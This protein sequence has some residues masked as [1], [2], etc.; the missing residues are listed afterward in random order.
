M[1]SNPQTILVYVGLDRI[2]DSLLKLPFIQN[3]RAAFPESYITWVAGKD[4]SV[5][6]NIMEPFIKGLLDEVI[7]NAGIGISPLE[8]INR[9]MKD[10][11]FDLIID[12]QRVALASLVL[13]RIQHREFISPFGN[14]FFSNRKPSPGYNFPK[15]M[16]RQMLDLLEIATGN[17]IDTPKV[18]ALRIEPFLL[19]EAKRALPNGSAYVGLFPGS[20]GKPKCWPLENFIE[21]AKAQIRAKRIPVFFLGPKEVDWISEIAAKVPEAIFPLQDG[22]YKEFLNYEPQWTIALSKRLTVSVSNDS[23]AGH[24]C[25]AG[26]RPLISLFG[27]TS[28][29]KFRP[30]SSKLTIIKAQ[31]YGGREMCFIPVNVV[32]SVIEGVI[33]KGH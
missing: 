4:T 14:F 22:S 27:R 28:P 23:G 31:D 26:G 2:G 8:I 21:I 11:K 20:G 33:E 7:E 15:S 30:M 24:M 17:K 13:W 3:L 18:L 9:P 12:T 25:A 10:R 29:E 6:G 19:R 1:N 16:Q 32:N 5:Y